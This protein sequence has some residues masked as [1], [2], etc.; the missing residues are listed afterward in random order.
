[1]RAGNTG[2]SGQCRSGLCINGFYSEG[3]CG[4]GGP[5]GMDDSVSFGARMVLNMTP[6]TS[7][8]SPHP[9]VRVQ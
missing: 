2:R 6:W 8:A 3:L 4:S 7:D 1:M 9:E 5:G